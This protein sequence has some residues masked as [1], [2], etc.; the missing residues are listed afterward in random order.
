MH[1]DSWHAAYRGLVPE[2]TLQAFT[3]ERREECWREFLATS[4]G[5]TYMVQS[6]NEIVGILTLGP[7]RDA[8]VDTRRTGEIWGLYISPGHW[9]K[10]I[11]RQVVAGAEQMLQSRG[12]E[13][14]VLWVVEA[15]DRAKRFY[16]AMGFA[17]DGAS[18]EIDWG[19]PVRA[20]RYRKGL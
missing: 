14:V 2:S 7:A 15:N 17:L 18:L 4:A 20:V 8:D 5:E 9:R 19:T 13:V 1:V 11:G 3:Y 10:G 16:E 12:Y 6:A